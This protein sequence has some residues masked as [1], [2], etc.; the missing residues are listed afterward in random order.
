ML[1]VSVV[2]PCLDDA[3]ALQACLESLRKQT[4]R[5][6]EVIVVDNGSTDDSVNVAGRYGAIV[7]HEPTPGIASAAAAGYDTATGS[8]IARCDA[9]SI[10]PVNWIEDIAEAFDGDPGLAALTGPGAFYGVGCFRRRVLDVLYMYGYFLAV[11]SAL[12][13]VPLFGSNFAIRRSC[14]EAVSGEV[15]RCD[16][17]MHDDICL[18][19]HIGLRS[20]ISFSRSLQ[21]G[22]SP[23]A[24]A[25]SRNVYVRFRRAF[26]TL[27]AHGPE[28]LPWNRWR[29]RVQQ[30]SRVQA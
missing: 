1:A 30:R 11:G 17:W 9:D 22:I 2:I 25:G 4:V 18:S 27:G 23:R 7:V 29:R 28:N 3:A 12:A 21:V 6:A 10:L 13:H 24:V 26:H 16:Q 5:P 14:W 15:H 19:M 8:V 20:R